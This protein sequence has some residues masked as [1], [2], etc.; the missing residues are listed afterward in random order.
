MA[1]GRFRRLPDGDGAS[2]CR[3]RRPRQGTLQCRSAEG[4]ASQAGDPM[5][6]VG[7]FEPQLR[8]IRLRRSIALW[9][10]AGFLPWGVFVLAVFPSALALGLLLVW[11]VAWLLF[12]VLW[13][14][15]ICPR[16]GKWFF[17]RT[18]FLRAK[19]FGEM[20]MNCDLPL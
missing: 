14:C 16:C 15:S 19:P 6:S 13:G 9:L 12:L 11:G 5:N 1:F 3:E 20:C 10:F 7:S 4:R 17:A 8:T 18:P 2:G